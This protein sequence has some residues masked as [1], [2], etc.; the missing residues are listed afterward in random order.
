MI[1]HTDKI[2]EN[3]HELGIEAF[4]RFEHT[5]LEY[6][7]FNGGQITYTHLYSN[8]NSYIVYNNLS[9]TYTTC[10]NVQEVCKSC[11]NVHLVSKNIMLNY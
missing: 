10:Y 8:F 4:I 3:L 6:I 2:L 5:H 11:Y 9:N 1:H 7:S